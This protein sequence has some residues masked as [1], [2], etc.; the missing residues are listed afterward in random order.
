MPYRPPQ[1]GDLLHIH[2]VARLPH[3][4]VIAHVDDDGRTVSITAGPITVW[5]TRTGPLPEE[6]TVSWLTDLVDD[7]KTEAQKLF[8]HD[9]ATV[10]AV[11]AKIDEKADAVKTAV[12]TDGEALATDASHDARAVAGEA[13]AEI[14]PAVAAAEGD[15]EGLEKQAERDGEQIADEAK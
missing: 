10:K 9:D 14:K 3:E 4:A 1:P 6:T 7:I 2:T 5:W 15:A 12:E 8:G 13:A 11:A